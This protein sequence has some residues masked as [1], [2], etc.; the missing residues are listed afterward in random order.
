M[1]LL[2]FEL[3]HTHRVSSSSRAEGRSR[4]PEAC[5]AKG[6]VVVILPMDIEQELAV[7]TPQ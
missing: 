6:E 5:T 7:G 2:L 4:V 1:V 3:C